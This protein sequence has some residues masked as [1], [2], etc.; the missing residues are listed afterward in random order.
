MKVFWKSSY[1]MLTNPL[2][3]QAH[4]HIKELQEISDHN[5]P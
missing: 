4:K 5:L 1:A 2:Y 3:L